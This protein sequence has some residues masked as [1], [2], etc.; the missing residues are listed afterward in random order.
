MVTVA[1]NLVGFRDNH[2]HSNNI[3]RT[4]IPVVTMVVPT[5]A[6]LV[7]TAAPVEAALVVALMVSVIAAQQRWRRW[8]HWQF[9]SRS[10]SW[11]QRR[12]RRLRWQ[13]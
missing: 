6:A 4:G 13:Q 9:P 7:T 10:L 3:G 5:T 12:W 8:R 1:V 2:D 11:Q